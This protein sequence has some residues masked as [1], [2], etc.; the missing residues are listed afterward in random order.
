MRAECGCESRASPV[1]CER[2]SVVLFVCD[3]WKCN[4]PQQYRSRALYIHASASAH[5][6]DSPFNKVTV[7]YHYLRHLSNCPRVCRTG[8]F[9]VSAMW[10]FL[11][12]V[13]PMTGIGLF[14]GLHLINADFVTATTS[15]SSSWPIRTI[16]Y[17]YSPRYSKS[18]TSQVPGH[19]Y[20]AFK[21]RIIKNVNLNSPC[22][23]SW[24]TF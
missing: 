3:S 14:A 21:N 8:R 17:R 9:L 4:S 7:H 2:H 24:S 10:H 15:R 22:W 19:P 13:V 6:Y 16:P 11:R 23:V 5:L 20:N 12:L 1:R 18:I